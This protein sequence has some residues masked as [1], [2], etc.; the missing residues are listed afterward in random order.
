M[1]I[2]WV[3]GADL[4]EAHW[5]AFFHFYMD[6][7]SRKWGSPY[8]NRKF[9]SLITESMADRILLIMCK[10]A[11]RHIAGALNFIGSDT[12]YGRN[13]GCIEDHPFLHFETCYYQAIEFAISRGLKHVEAGAQG[14]HK[15]AR[16]YVPEPTYSAHWIRDQGF[17]SAIEGFLN[18][19]RDYVLQDIEYLETRTPFRRD[20]WGKPLDLS[21]ARF[22]GDAAM[23][24]EDPAGKP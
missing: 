15:I 4:T 14:Q 7:G 10:R 11:G 12:L 21:Q 18:E 8:L 23:P 17:R 19:E 24:P 20:Q 13:W 9:F 22:S 3:T 1:T 6:T 5:D 16:G 2:E